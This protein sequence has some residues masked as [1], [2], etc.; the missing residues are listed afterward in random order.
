MVQN[1]MMNFIGD[2][3]KLILLDILIECLFIKMTIFIFLRAGKFLRVFNIFIGTETESSE[4]SLTKN[5][6]ENDRLMTR[7]PQ[8][9]DN[10]NLLGHPVYKFLENHTL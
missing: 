2:M 1:N 7:N 6:I 3:I 9:N 10:P 5:R 8:I 4:L